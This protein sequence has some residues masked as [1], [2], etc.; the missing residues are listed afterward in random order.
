MTGPAPSADPILELRGV[1]KTFGVVHVLHDVDFCVYPGQVTA[2]VGDNGA[3]KS[4]LVKAIAGIHPIDTGTY[5]FEGRARDGARSER[6]VIALG[7][8]IVYQDLALCDNLD[9][10]Q[11]MFLGRELHQS[12]ICWTRP[13]WRR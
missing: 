13:G 10:V 7:V 6:G 1:N 2:L 8:E 4:T 5:L 11:N 9:I 12:G 3:G